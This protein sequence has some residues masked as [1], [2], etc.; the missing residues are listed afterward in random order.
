MKL[1]FPRQGMWDVGDKGEPLGSRGRLTPRQRG[2][3]LVISIGMV[4]PGDNGDRGYARTFGCD[5]G[6]LSPPL[7]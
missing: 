5:R 6:N 3:Y 2:R 1:P 7:C 4:G